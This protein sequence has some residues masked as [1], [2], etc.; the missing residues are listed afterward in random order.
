MR[1]IKILTR[2]L[3]LSYLLSALLLTIL[4]FALFRLKLSPSRVS[5]GV[6]AIYGI[7]CFLG[8]VLAGKGLRSRKFFWGLLSGLLYFILLALMSF[9]LCKGLAEDTRMLTSVLGICAGCGTIGGMVS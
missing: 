1:T 4:A 9:L 5:A 3:F 2:S 7:S 6:Y 8:G